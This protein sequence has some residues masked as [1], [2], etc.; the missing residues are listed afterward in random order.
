VIT[1][2]EGRAVA[3]IL[4]IIVF[5][6]AFLMPRREFFVLVFIIGLI[7]VAYSVP[8]I[9]LKKRLWVSNLTI[10]F[11]RG[12]L[13][14]VAAWSIFGDPFSEPTPWV[15]GG[16]MMIFLIGAIT[17]KDFT[18]IRGDRAYKIKTLPVVYGIRRS[19][20]ISGPFFVMPFVL[21]LVSLMAGFLKIG[22]F[23]L[24]LLAVWGIITALM[25]QT[26]ATREEK[27]FENSIV[28]VN[29]YLLLIAMQVFFAA[30]YV[31]DFE[32]LG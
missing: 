28:W 11:A 23:W 14:F 12:M 6:R 18:D 4:Y 10:A 27:T 22:M 21:I 17:S 32:I 20:L 13:G 19:A 30:T 29:M 7:T 24:V 15:I 16:V 9:R 1:R 31:F 8:P 26:V 2:E 3:W 25:M 5:A